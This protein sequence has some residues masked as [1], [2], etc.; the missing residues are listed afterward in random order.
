MA[1]WVCFARGSVSHRALQTSTVPITMTRTVSQ[2]CWLSAGLSWSWRSPTNTIPLGLLVDGPTQMF[3]RQCFGSVAALLWVWLTQL[4]DWVSSPSTL[5][6][7]V[8]SYSGLGTSFYCNL[9][10]AFFWILLKSATFFYVLFQIFLT[11]ETQKN[12]E[13]FCVLLQRT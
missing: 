3:S 6:T 5:M 7:Q 2:L 10:A 4:V 11:Y 9:S 13:F 8:D 1:V 12:V